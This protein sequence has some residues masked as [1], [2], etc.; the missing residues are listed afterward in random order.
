MIYIGIRSFI[1]LNVNYKDGSTGH[2]KYRLFD[3]KFDPNN[4]ILRC[5][6]RNKNLESK[7]NNRRMP[8]LSSDFNRGKMKG[9]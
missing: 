4:T 8:F 3:K 6:F 9:L 2:H 7:I 5:H 1:N